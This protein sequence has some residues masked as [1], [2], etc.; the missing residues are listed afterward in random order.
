MRD[1]KSAATGNWP[2]LLGAFL[3]FDTS[4]MVWMLPGT[5]AIFIAGALKL[6]PAQ[7]GL[8]VALPQLSGSIL[9]ILLG[10]ASDGFGT[11]RVAIV[12]MWLT[13]G[14][15]LFGWLSNA[16][17]VSVCIAALALGIAGASFAVAIPL[18][19]AW[20]PPTAQGL[21]LGITTAGNSGTVVAAAFAPRLAEHFGWQPVFGLALIPVGLML[22][23]FCLSAHEAPSQPALR[24][25]S[26]YFKIA[27]EPET[28]RLSLLYSVTFGGFV[29]LA[30]FLPVFLFEQYGVTPAKGGSL[31]A[32]CVLA[33][34][35]SQPLGGFL[36]DR[37]GGVR[38]L[39]C[40]LPAVAL[41]ALLLAAHPTLVV[42]AWL[43]TI[44]V[45][46]LGAGSGA[47]LQLV[48]GRIGKAVGVTRAVGVAT[49]IIGAAAGL[50][51]FVLPSL[52]SAARQ[53]TGNFAGGMALFATMAILA[54]RLVATAQ[55]LLRNDPAGAR[56]R[57]ASR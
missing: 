38:V 49:G 27:L 47:V 22:L 6:N 52:L 7:T 56:L 57:V 20:Y 21:V 30:S 17:F 5:L 8:L 37:G 28:W 11:R 2:T 45:A 42:G 18:A 12:A 16:S 46:G 23:A 29:G 44:I 32:L 43:L 14:A 39:S 25:A 51:G 41:L 34:S 54:W 26:D 48:P 13:L 3:Y 50:G 15:L 24:K 4:F 35:V 40:V 9:R 53:W 31:A 19:S 1:P 10:I 55:R 36:A 33:G